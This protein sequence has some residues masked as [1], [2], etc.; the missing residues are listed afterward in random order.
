MAIAR[1]IVLAWY[2]HQ[3]HLERLHQQPKKPWCVMKMEEGLEFF[4][5]GPKASEKEL[6]W[7]TDSFMNVDFDMIDWSAWE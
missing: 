3:E 6:G 7:D 5:N 4:M 1:L 2:Q